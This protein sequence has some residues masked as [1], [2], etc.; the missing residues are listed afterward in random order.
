MRA[1]IAEVVQRGLC[2]PAELNVE[3]AAGSGRG[4]ALPRE[5]LGEISDGVRSVAEADARK[6]VHRSGLPSP[7][8][9]ARIH[10]R[11]GRFVAMPDAWFEDVGMAWE[12]D[13][14]EWH[15]SPADYERT[16]DRRAAMM[17]PGIVVVHHM[18]KKLSRQ[19]EVVVNDSA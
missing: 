18:P 13:S 2:T 14:R 1:A 9:N 6:L 7:I 4:S 11:A 3:L 19:P 5:V 15:F 12:I 17:A 8:W 10:D 16:L